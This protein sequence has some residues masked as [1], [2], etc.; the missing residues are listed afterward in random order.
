MQ[1]PISSMQDRARRAEIPACVNRGTGPGSKPLTGGRVEKQLESSC[2]RQ[3][4]LLYQCAAQSLWQAS[5]T[6][7]VALEIARPEDETVGLLL[8]T[9]ALD[10]LRKQRLIAAVDEAGTRG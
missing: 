5:S 10:H 8:G 2:F 3:G 1:A 4:F 7:A 6:I 9:Q